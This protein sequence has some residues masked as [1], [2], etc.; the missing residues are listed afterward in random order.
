[1]S[2]RCK[3]W[4]FTR[5]KKYN[6]DNLVYESR[7]RRPLDKFPWVSGKRIDIRQTRNGMS[8]LCPVMVKYNEIAK[9][10][11]LREFSD[12]VCYC[13]HEQI[14][15]FIPRG[16]PCHTPCRT[17]CRVLE[18]PSLV[19]AISDALRFGNGELE[20]YWGKVVKANFS[21]FRKIN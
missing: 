13:D 10:D 17:R 7:V 16:V 5:Q 14:R 9:R 1:M 12:K 15:Q 3:V 21:I 8:V 18:N 4:D 20:P 2:Q 6:F 11:G 19:I